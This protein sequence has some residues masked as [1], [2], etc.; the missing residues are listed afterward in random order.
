MREKKI[1][2]SCGRSFEWRSKLAKNWDH[3][4][5]CSR[6][7]RRRRVSPVDLKLEQALLELLATRD[8]VSVCPSDAARKVAPSAEHWQ[9]LEE[10]ARRAARRLS[11]RRQVVILQ[12]GRSVDPDCFRG[13]I[14]VTLMRSPS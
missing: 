3:V 5:Y 14:R 12:R 2:A 8:V 1:C 10:P 11:H 6:A 9:S 4:R 13:E 7:C